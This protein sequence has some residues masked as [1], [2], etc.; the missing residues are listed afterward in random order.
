[1]TWGVNFELVMDRPDRETVLIQ[2]NG[3]VAKKF[4]KKCTFADV[5]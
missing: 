1:V 4:F 5:G 3:H 2:A